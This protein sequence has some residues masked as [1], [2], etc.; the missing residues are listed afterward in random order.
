MVTKL[1]SAWSNICCGQRNYLPCSDKVI[2][3]HLPF[4]FL[5]VLFFHDLEKDTSLCYA[6]LQI[7][8]RKTSHEFT[9]FSQSH[10][11]E[12]ISERLKKKKMLG[13]R[14]CPPGIPPFVSVMTYNDYVS[15]C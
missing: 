7:G 9:T 1:V 14:V 11:H 10:F 13:S 12:D 8:S 2:L 5:V 4:E 3:S 6:K 15:N